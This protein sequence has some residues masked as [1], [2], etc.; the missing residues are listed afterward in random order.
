M[1]YYILFDSNLTA[2][3]AVIHFLIT[4]FVYMISITVHEFAHAFAAYKAGD[5]TAKSMGRMTLNP[6]KH[7]SLSGFIMFMLL[8]VGWAKPV[9]TNPL[10]YKKYRSGTRW[11]AISGILANFLLG[12]VSAI[13]T[14]ILLATVG[15]ST[16]LVIGYIYNILSYFMIINSFLFM[17]N[18]LPVPPLDGFNFITSFMKGENKFIKFMLKNGFKILLGIL[19]GSALLDML[20]GI[21]ILSVY[22]SLLNGLVYMP[23]VFLGVL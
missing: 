15:L 9:P 19:I 11:V 16:G 10:N 13:T 20:F 4:I 6:F 22:I 2:N 14:A 5:P 8:G 17:F 7:I 21:D 18:I 1:L 23:I 12:L 3:E